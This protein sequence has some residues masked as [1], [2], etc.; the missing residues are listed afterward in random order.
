MKDTQSQNPLSPR[1]IATTLLGGWFTVL[2][3]FSLGD[4]TIIS[5]EMVYTQKTWLFLL[6]WVAVC[7]ALW[8]YATISQTVVYIFS[9]AITLLYTSRAAWLGGSYPLTFGLCGVMVLILALALPCIKAPK[10][11]PH[12]SQKGQV[13]LTSLFELLCGGWMLFLLI[14]SYL[15]YTTTPSA[16]TAVYA[17]MLSSMKDTL[18][19]YTSLEFG[20]WTSHFA[21]HI[22]P[23][24][25]VYLPFYMVAPSPITLM[26]LQTI[27][28][29]SALTPLC[30]IARRKGLTF[31][32][33]CLISLLFC[34][35]PTLF[36]G[37]TGGVHEYVW[38]IPLLLWLFWA[39]EAEKPWLVGLFA[40]LSLCVRETAA[41]YLITIGLYW[42][43]THGRGVD[44]AHKKA[45][46]I[47]LCLM[48]GAAIYFT[49]AL[50]ILTYLGKGT[51]ITR[52]ANV[53]GIYNT[54]IGTLIKEIFMNPSVVIYE[55]LTPEK[56]Y[57]LLF[58][59]LPLGIL[60]YLAKKKAMLVFL[61]PLCLHHLLSDF[62]YHFNPSYPYALCLVPILFYLVTDAMSLYQTRQEADKSK[63][64]WGQYMVAAMCLTLIIGC[65][66]EANTSY[67]LE[68]LTNGGQEVATLNDTL[69]AIPPDASVSASGRL[70]P[71]LT[72]HK[73]LYT[74]SQNKD[75]DYVIIDLR[76][77]WQA[78]GEIGVD[79]KIY[80]DKGYE[81]VTT[82]EG[83]VAVCQKK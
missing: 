44:V 29:L 47:G 33:I 4:V 20:E 52:F 57:F 79:V 62:A 53:T 37:L 13:I 10:N 61:I 42:L 41:I 14:S 3:F 25:Y 18:L 9:I 60:P 21:L 43:I 64:K 78:A 48:I 74:L 38:L 36:G 68:Y 7:G 55:I 66:F 11:L 51:L 54:T 59:L 1:L 49:S 15:T 46:R 30:L 63:S 39:L 35:F 16:S 27:V 50:L 80:T 81:I 69:D 28:A 45:R 56:L 32:Q 24:F 17:Q 76:E 5:P 2:F 73:E 65:F 70:I 75:T 19:P 67:Q 72:S 23:I 71:H 58:L 12:L 82:I 22:S 26:V 31:G 40:C 83:V 8:L 34:L 6:I 77:E